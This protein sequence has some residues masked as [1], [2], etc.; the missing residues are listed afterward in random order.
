MK[1]LELRANVSQRQLS[2]SKL[3]TGR[4]AELFKAL[5]LLTL[6]RGAL[7]LGRL[8]DDGHRREHVDA[9][10]KTLGALFALFRIAELA[11]LTDRVAALASV[12]IED[13]HGKFLWAFAGGD[14]PVEHGILSFG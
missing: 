14:H 4:A 3:V 9:S 6:L 7:F 10:F 12:S 5:S 1:V 11:L 8:D 13:V 2:R